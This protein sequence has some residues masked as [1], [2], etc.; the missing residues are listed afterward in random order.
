[1]HLTCRVGLHNATRRWLTVLS[2]RSSPFFDFYTSVKGVQQGRILLP[3]RIKW[4]GE[5]G[6][7]QGGVAQEFFQEVSLD[8]FHNPHDCVWPP[9]L[10]TETEENSGL[11]WPNPGAIFSHDG[12][13]YYYF[14]VLMGLAI[15]NGFTFTVSLPDLF[16]EKIKGIRHEPKL[17]LLQEAWPQKRNSLQNLLDNRIDKWG[18]DYVFSCPIPP[19]GYLLKRD[20][21][22]MKAD[23]KSS[24]LRLEIPLSPSAGDTLP[25][26]HDEWNFELFKKYVRSDSNCLNPDPSET[27]PLSDQ[28]KDAYVS[29]CIDYLLH[30]TV[31]S[32]FREIR[33]GLAWVISDDLLDTISPAALRLAVQGRSDIDVSKVRQLVKLQDYEASD[34][35]IL[36]FWEIVSSWSSAN[37]RKLLQFVTACERLPVNVSAQ[38]PAFTIQQSSTNN[39]ETLPMATT[40]TRCLILPRYPSK[41][42]MEEKLA[43]VLEGYIG[44]GRP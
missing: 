35:T 13:A 11:Y 5:E 16:Y 17:D 20:T 15:H 23:L 34:D 8:A 38:Y 30:T 7:D 27:R 41:E 37:I 36:W 24:N 3:L 33:R 31:A 43:W 32:Q 6:V 18:L 26:R 4:K 39:P 40:C 9:K 42:K 19:L 14:G 1:M 22:E 28:N 12:E 44:F 10:F 21:S 2:E 25:Q 29:V